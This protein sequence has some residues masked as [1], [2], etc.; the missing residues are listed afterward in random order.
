MDRSSVNISAVDADLAEGEFA[1]VEPPTPAPDLDAPKEPDFE[2]PL[3]AS[4]VVT[5][6]LIMPPAADTGLMPIVSAAAEGADDTDRQDAARTKA[7][8]QAK[9]TVSM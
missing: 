3:D 6:L 5:E 9:P 4:R 8:V 1:P 2:P 7:E